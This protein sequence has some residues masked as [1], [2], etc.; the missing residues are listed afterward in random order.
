MSCDMSW[1]Y[2]V[3]K[4]KIG[5]GFVYEVH[6]VYYNLDG[7]IRSWTENPINPAGGTSEE[8]KKDFAQQLLAFD[9]SVLDYDALN[10]QTKF[11]D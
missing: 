3:F 1:D 2:R 11:R 10:L 9:S 7:T 8:L 5:N 4:K 6:E